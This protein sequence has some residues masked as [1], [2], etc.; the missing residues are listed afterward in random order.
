M[1]IM[2]AI[3]DIAENGLKLVPCGHEKLKDR[4]PIKVH[5]GSI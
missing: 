1:N 3:L 4:C 2:A 5:Q